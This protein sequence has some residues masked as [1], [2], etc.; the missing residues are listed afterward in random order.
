[1]KR[2]FTS[3]KIGERRTR[4]SLRIEDEPNST[5]P[6]EKY[7]RQVGFLQDLV[8]QP[9]LLAC[10]GTTLEKISL[11]HTGDFWLL[12]GEVEVDDVS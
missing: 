3:V 9:S 4:Y 2:F 7:Q 6:L 1:M 8:Q 5:T 11:V 12:T 10:G